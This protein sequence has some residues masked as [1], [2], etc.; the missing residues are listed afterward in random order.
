MLDALFGRANRGDVGG[1]GVQS[2]QQPRAAAATSVVPEMSP[3][4]REPAYASLSN[5]YGNENQVRRNQA[6]TDNSP[7]QA[8]PTV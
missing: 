2:Q 5:Y 1:G 4:S 7:Q 8:Y 6:V 3:V